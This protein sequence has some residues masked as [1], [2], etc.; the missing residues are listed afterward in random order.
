MFV[1]VYVCLRAHVYN[2]AKEFTTRQTG[3]F[4][5][6]VIAVS[7]KA[8]HLQ[9]ASYTLDVYCSSFNQSRQKL[10][11]TPCSP[12]IVMMMLSLIWSPFFLSLAVLA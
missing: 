2:K 6:I 1:C 12:L 9:C 3:Q 5:D 11:T 10:L 7:S 8:L 4:Y